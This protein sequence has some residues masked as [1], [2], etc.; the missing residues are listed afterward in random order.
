MSYWRYRCGLWGCPVTSDA[1]L[2]IGLRWDRHRNGFDVSAR[3]E[4][5][6]GSTDEWLSPDEPL[7]IDLDK[8]Q[9]L[10][11]DE[12]AY[13]KA[14]TDMVLRRADIRPFYVKAR[15]ASELNNLKLHLRLHLSAPARFHALRWESLRDPTYET[16]IAMRSNVLFSRYLSSP[17]WR[18][19]PPLAKHEL[20]ALIVVAA[21]TDLNEYRPGGR[22]LGQVRVEEELA[23]A[24]TALSDMPKT[25][26]IGG[27]ATLANVL[28]AVDQGVD[29]LYLICHGAL[30][31]D[32]PRLYLEN[33]DRTAD[34]VDGRK[35]A[36]ALSELQRRPTVVMLCSC[37]SAGAGAQVCS[38]DKG[39]LSALGP[40][41]ATAGVAA[42]VGMQGNISMTTA[43]IFAPAFFAELARHGLVDEAMATAR[44]S[45]HDQ[46]DWWVPVLFSRLR[47]GRTYYIPEFA[48]RAE[49]TWDELLLQIRTGNLTPVLGPELVSAIIGSRED[50]ARRWVQRWQMPIA[51]S[52]Q[53]DL[54]QVAQYL[55][56]RSAEGTVRARVQEHL[57][58]EI[59][60]HQKR[61]TPD[62]PLWSLPEE[63]VE[64][65]EPAPAIKELGR[66]LR[67][68]DPGDPHR[69]MATLPVKVYVTTGWTSFLEDALKEHDREP[70]VISF[71][72]N[73]PAETELP[74]VREPTPQRPLV[75][76]LYGQLDD[77][78]SLV[79]TEDDYFAWLS[80]WNSRRKSVPPLVRKALTAKSLMFLGY[81]LGNW[82]FRVVFQGIRNLGGSDLLRLNRHVG[83]Q[84]N[85][86]SPAIEPEAAQEYLESYLGEEKISIYWGTTRH[87]LDELRRRTGIAT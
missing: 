9:R 35:L 14:L 84:L 6:D 16:P 28:E 87:F 53:E 66:R 64:G 26:L 56:V 41:L 7:V 31:D 23:R 3:F 39:E 13:G 38:A 48:S 45:I 50:I 36:E 77:P 82:D 85:P 10:G 72:W 24:Q 29:I 67:R 58:D 54:A 71:P 78:W 75:Y 42:V 59:R 2:E 74:D 60:Q 52:S 4:I 86:D 32:V 11:A 27:D 33:P 79:L 19:I 65:P 8:L 5:I 12:P 83:V 46:R 73:Q 21:P 61:A 76:H 15:G 80:A 68:I 18:P 44:Q 57:M 1:D 81:R 47:S 40:R 34:V 49:Q 69:V 51:H 22:V 70:M 30:I 55:R 43:G 17:D 20:H 63:L 62:D 37:Q 25:E